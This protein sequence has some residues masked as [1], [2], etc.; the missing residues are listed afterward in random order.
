MSCRPPLNGWANAAQAV[1]T[2][3]RQ[4]SRGG[5]GKFLSGN[6]LL[7]FGARKQNWRLRGSWTGDK[8]LSSKRRGVEDGFVNCL[9]SHK[10]CGKKADK[11]DNA[12]AEI[13]Q[14]GWFPNTSDLGRPAS[15]YH[16]LGENGNYR[17]AVHITTIDA[18]CKCNP[19]RRGKQGMR[20]CS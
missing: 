5:E 11:A 7:D 1:G 14:S 10:A 3:G 15:T 12:F 18:R 17:Q 20:Q 13:H 4:D 6:R 16:A 2:S 9:I 19:K 8:P